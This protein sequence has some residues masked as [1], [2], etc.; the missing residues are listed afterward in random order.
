MESIALGCMEKLCYWHGVRALLILSQMHF[1]NNLMLIIDI[2]T[3][4]STEYLQ[5]TQLY[6]ILHQ[7][8]R[9]YYQPSEGCAIV[10]MKKKCEASDPSL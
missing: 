2:Y 7:R 8:V 4:I 3:M 1:G 5:A 6:P 10:T 9:S